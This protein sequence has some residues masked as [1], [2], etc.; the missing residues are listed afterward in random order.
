MARVS[1]DGDGF[2]SEEEAEFA[3]ETKDRE[4]AEEARAGLREATTGEALAA[5]GKGTSGTATTVASAAPVETAD[6]LHEI[7]ELISSLMA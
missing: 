5:S 1:R 6:A 3:Q 7:D 2:F 4:A